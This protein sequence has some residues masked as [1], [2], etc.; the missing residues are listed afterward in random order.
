MVEFQSGLS[1]KPCEY[2]EVLNCAVPQQFQP[3]KLGQGAKS[4]LNA[5]KSGNNS[6]Q[7][8]IFDFEKSERSIIDQQGC[9]SPSG[10]GEGSGESANKK[11][12]KLAELGRLWHKRLG[13]PGLKLLV[14]TSK[15]T[16]GMPNLEGLTEADIHCQVC[17]QAKMLRHPSKGPLA[18]PPKALDSIEGDIFEMSPQSHN[19]SSAVLLLVDRKTRYRWAF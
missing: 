1:I 19:K 18:D 10:A 5:E 9:D 12:F 16:R 17:T 4:V 14:K 13:H 8:P 2:V 15:I 3:F 7:S 11:P 6:S